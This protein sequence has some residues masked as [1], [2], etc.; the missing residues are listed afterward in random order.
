LDGVGFAEG[1]FG[2]GAEVHVGHDEGGE[3]GEWF[4]GQF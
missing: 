1:G 2:D 3:G 4:F